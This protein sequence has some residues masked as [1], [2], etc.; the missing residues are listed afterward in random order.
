MLRV[1]VWVL[2]AALVLAGLGLR[3]SGDSSGTGMIVPGLVIV[4]AMALERWRYRPDT[5]TGEAGWT[6]TGERFV[7]PETHRL[8]EVLFNPRT[9]ERRYTEVADAA[10]GDGEP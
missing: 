2:G 6:R 7:D 4:A 1:A 3:L 10:R 8:T 9:G 5:G